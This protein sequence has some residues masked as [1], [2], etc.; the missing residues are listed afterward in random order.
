MRGL[1]ECALCYLGKYSLQKKE[2]AF[3]F[4]DIMSCVK[5]VSHIRCTYLLLE[6][7]NREY[8]VHR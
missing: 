7:K 5:S 8:D 1:D 6:L 4:F 3:W 2:A